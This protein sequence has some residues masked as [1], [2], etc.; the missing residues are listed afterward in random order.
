[1]GL[2]AFKGGTPAKW[3]AISSYIASAL[4]YMLAVF[5]GDISI[6]TTC[7]NCLVSIQYPYSLV[8]FFAT[9]AAIGVLFFGITLSL[10]ILR[11]RTAKPGGR[12]LLGSGLMSAGVL[13]IL[14][15]VF[16][17]LAN[18]QDEGP[19]CLGGCPPSTIQYYQTVYAAS[20]ILALLG[21]VAAGSGAWLLIRRVTVIQSS[22]R[23]SGSETSD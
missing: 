10:A 11:R 21:L 17:Y 7:S 15:A 1:L 4:L 13:A 23:E 20:T 2:A 18:W 8:S 16:W 3:V 22:S 6:R 12:P 9:L 5:T 14:F 19:R